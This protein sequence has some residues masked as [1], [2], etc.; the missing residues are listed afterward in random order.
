M[1]TP[2][3]ESPLYGLM[4]EFTTEY[5]FV[6]ACERSYEAGYRKQ[7]GFSPY[8]VEEASHALGHHKSWVP[9]LVLCAG[10][11]GACAGFG[12]QYWTQAVDYTMNIGGRPF[13]SWPAFIPVTFEVTILFAGITAVVGMLALNGLPRPHHPVFNVPSF[14]RASRDRYFLLIEAE[15][16]QFD[17]E[18]TEA[19]LRSLDPTEVTEVER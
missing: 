3:E 18:H 13:N 5:E 12:L 19:F 6:E 1:H 11:C 15:D 14:V 7:D 4:A 17:R 9:T 10:I 8:P 2:Q 16:P